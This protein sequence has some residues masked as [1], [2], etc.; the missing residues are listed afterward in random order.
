V[1]FA[2]EREM[3]M[4]LGDVLHRRTRLSLFDRE[5]G[6]GVAKHVARRMAAPLKWDAKELRA[7]MAAYEA[8]L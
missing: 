1:E 2:I 6:R 7:Q 8:S 4:T 3:A 5:Q